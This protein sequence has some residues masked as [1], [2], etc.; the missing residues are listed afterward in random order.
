MP[1]YAVTMKHSAVSCPIFNEETKKKFREG[2]G[3]RDEAAKK[4]K[5]KVLTACVAVL[6][7][8]VFYVV[9]A[10]SQSA[11]EDYLR[12]TGWAFYNEIQI[13]EVQPV[14]EVVKRFGLT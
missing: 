11:V 7:H 12:E 4:N 10:P 2:A 1:A 13:R 14:E 6:E 9:D 3:K 5:V 8:L